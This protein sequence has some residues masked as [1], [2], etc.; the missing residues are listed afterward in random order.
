[1]VRVAVIGVGALA[2]SG[3]LLPPEQGR[4]TSLGVP[5]Y[6]SIGPVTRQV[7]CHTRWVLTATDAWVLEMRT[8]RHPEPLSSG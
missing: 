7:F 8:E 6:R 1:M 3:K 4:A 2:Y 5:A